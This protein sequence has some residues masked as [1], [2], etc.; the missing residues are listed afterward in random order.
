MIKN[1]TCIQCPQ[2]CQ[3]KVDIENSYVIKVAGNK[4]PKGEAY[5][6]Q[7]IENPLRTLAS[8]VLAKGLELKIVP[9]KT[10]QP[11]PKAKISEAM[12][13]I[14]KIFLT[15]PVSCGEVIEKNFLGLD[16]D[17]IATRTA[18]RL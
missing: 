3:L 10:A 18:N 13:R 16:V 7:E 11:I 1:M 4:C 17:L 9:V 8:G 14:K 5:A 12:E 15:K 2:G 6:K